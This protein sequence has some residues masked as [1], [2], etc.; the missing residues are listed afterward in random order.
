LHNTAITTT[1]SVLNKLVINNNYNNNNQQLENLF[2]VLLFPG[3]MIRNTA[4]NNLRIF[5]GSFESQVLFHQPEG[6][7]GK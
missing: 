7:G 1:I 4:Q 5:L 2:V 6:E 3:Q